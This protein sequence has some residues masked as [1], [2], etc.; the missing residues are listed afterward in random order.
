MD[1]IFE[2]SLQKTNELLH[3][4]EDK[5]GW[6]DRKNQ[7]YQALR[8]VLHSLRDR[9]S[10]DMVI[11]FSA[12]LPLFIKGILIEGWKFEENPI[13]YNREEFLQNIA[14]QLPYTVE[15]LETL[16]SAVLD[17]LRDLIGDEEIE[18]IKSLMPNGLKEIF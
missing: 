4:I 3:N 1:N 15:D 14:F 2:P 10:P 13:K 5:M 11:K 8:A 16:F 17:S 6:E 18:K 12:Q 7:A 9:M